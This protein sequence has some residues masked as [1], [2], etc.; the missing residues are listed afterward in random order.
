MRIE[1]QKAATNQARKDQQTEVLKPLY[2]IKGATTAWKLL[3]S[4]DAGIPQI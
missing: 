1:L 4:F 3:S 2:S